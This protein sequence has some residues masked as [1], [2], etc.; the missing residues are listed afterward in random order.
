MDKTIVTGSS[1]FIGFSLAKHLLENG[2]RVIGIDKHDGD[3][4][5]A[6]L[7]EERHRLLSMYKNYTSIRR[8]LSN[9]IT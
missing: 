8:D 9:N 7:Q 2:F 3:G 4:I 5:L 1:G 6:C